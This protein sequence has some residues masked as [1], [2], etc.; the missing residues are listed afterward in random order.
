MNVNRLFFTF[1]LHF[2][3]ENVL[4][5]VFCRPS[6]RTGLTWLFKDKFYIVFEKLILY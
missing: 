1:L 6:V 5:S 2:D 4:L 3:R